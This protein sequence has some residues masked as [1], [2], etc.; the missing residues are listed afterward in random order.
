MELHTKKILKF[1]FKT[2]ETKYHKLDFDIKLYY[3]FFLR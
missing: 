1:F 3:H 2:F